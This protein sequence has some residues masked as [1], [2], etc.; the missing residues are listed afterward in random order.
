[1]VLV[2]LRCR[3]L[4]TRTSRILLNLVLALAWGIG[5]LSVTALQPVSAQSNPITIENARQ[6][7]TNWRLTRPADD[8]NHQIKAYASRSSVTSGDRIRFYVSTNPPQNF[9]L[10]VFRIGFYNG[11]GGRQM[12]QSAWRSSTTQS[13]CPVTPSTGFIRCNWS[14]NLNITIPSDWTTGVYLAKFTSA[15]GYDNYVPFVVR[16]DVR[17]PDF[18]YQQPVTTYHAYNAYPDDGQRGKSSYNVFSSG[19]PTIAGTP[20]AVRISYD[21]PLENTGA[22]KFL[23]YEQDLIMF[24]EEHG[25]DIGYQNN[26]DTHNNGNNLTRARGFISPGHDEYWTRENFDAVERARDNGVHLAFFGA[27][28]AF[29]QIRLTDNP[30]SGDHRVMDIYKNAGIDPEPVFR[31]KTLTFRALGRAEQQLTGVQYAT[32][33][34]RSDDTDFIARNTSHWIYQNTGL[35]SG[36]RISGI[37]GVEIDRVFSDFPVADAEQFTVIGRSPFQGVEFPNPV[38]SEAV[39][40]RAASGAWVFASGTLLWTQGLN[41]PGLRSEPLR[42]MTR[43]L[44]DRF[45]G[46]GVQQNPTISV[47]PLTVQE[48]SGVAN[49]EVRLSE[50]ASNP[51]QFR[52]ATSEGS[53]KKYDDF[54][55][56]SRNMTIAAGQTVAVIPVTIRND[57]LNE[58]AESFYGRFYNVSGAQTGTSEATITIAASDNDDPNGGTPNLSIAPRQVPETIGIASLSVTLDSA[59]SETVR[60]EYATQAD[61]ARAGSDFHGKYGVLVFQPGETSKTIDIRILNDTAKETTESLNVRMF[62]PVRA[63]LAQNT[64]RLTIQ[65]ND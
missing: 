62:R 10:Q 8:R 30:A 12:Y 23:K 1:M 56:L 24:L 46:S 59:T 65:D 55:G 3:S 11:A 14:E 17:D 26:L 22:E 63:R 41:R 20:R 48:S 54:F 36:D 15:T 43:N 31:N 25:Y 33:G 57:N 42:Q 28:T 13:T 21:R 60:I 32:Y 29:W 5:S 51:V 49:V 44:L 27:N 52:F 53:A 64:A 45:A 9:R 16:D 2:R 19:P 61:S 35:S 6:G 37:V 4:Q 7:T 39:V 58:P 34:R 38:N 18:I 40:Y 50:P 47:Q